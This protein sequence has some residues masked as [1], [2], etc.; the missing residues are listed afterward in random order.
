V[1]PA[2]KDIANVRLVKL[3]VEMHVKICRR[4]HQT[5]EHVETFVP[6]ADPALKE[7]ANVRLVRLFVERHVKTCRL[8]C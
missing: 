5:A 7:F 1:D 6:V 4:I 2:L 3:I 8:I